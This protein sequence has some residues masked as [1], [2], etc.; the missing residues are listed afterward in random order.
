LFY[1]YKR[2]GVEGYIDKTD[3]EIDDMVKENLYNSR[4][5]LGARF[6]INTGVAANRDKIERLTSG[7]E[8]LFAA[9]LGKYKE[10]KNNPEDNETPPVYGE[11]S[12][13]ILYGASM[14]DKLYEFIKVDDNYT[15]IYNAGLTAAEEL[16]RDFAKDK[17]VYYLKYPP[18]K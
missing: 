16:R 1:K 3:A 7:E 8:Y 15:F 6:A 9:S 13:E 18:Y 17:Y 12:P 2:N 5:S 11:N 14:P 4:Y 10:Y